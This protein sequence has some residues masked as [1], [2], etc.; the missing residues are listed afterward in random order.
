MSFLKS[1]I[2]PIQKRIME[3]GKCP[4]CG[5]ELKSQKL[6]DPLTTDSEL[7]YCVCGRAFVF[8]R[9]QQRYRRALEEE[10][11][12]EGPKSIKLSSYTY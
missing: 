2:A 8:S 6:R 11:R 3:K 4:G 7:V 10:I 12:S 9:M 5:R 1:L